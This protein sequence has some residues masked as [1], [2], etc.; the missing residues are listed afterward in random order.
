[1]S[2]PVNTSHDEDVKRLHAQGFGRNDIVRELGVPAGTVS[3]IAKRHGLKFDGSQVL[4][5][6]EVRR[7]EAAER[8]AT[9]SISFL[10]DVERLRERLFGPITYIQYGG[11]EFERRADRMSQPMPADQAAIARSIGMLID[12][13]IKIDEYDRTGTTLDDA[14]NFLDGVQVVI[15]GEVVPMRELEKLDDVRD[16]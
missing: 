9:M 8:R 15:R 14:H 6:T 10:D 5:A 16:E 11:K 2:R 3:T 12:R 1:M 7:R 4:M 13:A